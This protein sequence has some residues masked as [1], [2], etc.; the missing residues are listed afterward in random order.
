LARL[1]QAF[2]QLKLKLSR[3]LSFALVFVN[4]YFPIF[5]RQSI[6]LFYFL[7]K[8]GLTITEAFRMGILT[9]YYMVEDHFKP[10]NL[11]ALPLPLNFKY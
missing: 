8:K 7:N 10:S 4:K 2:S 6:N 9:T 5:D 3:P 1:V 11:S